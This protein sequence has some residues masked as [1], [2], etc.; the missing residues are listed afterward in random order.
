MIL[1]P[2]IDLKDGSVIR[3]IRG[4]A[5][6]MYVCEESAVILG[7][8]YARQGFRWLHVV[9]LNGATT[10]DMCNTQV[11][12]EILAHVNIPIQLG[13]GIRSLKDVEHWISRGVHRV[14]MG[15]AA[16][17]NPELIREAC[18]E[19][20]GKICVSI[21]AVQ[22]RVSLSGWTKT[23]NI[24]ALELALRYEDAG[25]SAIIY[26]D[27]TLDDTLN[28]INIDAVSDMA[29]ALTTPLIASGGLASIA[30]IEALKR[31][32]S[33]GIVGMVCGR[34]MYDGRIDP[35]EA[36][37]VAGEQEI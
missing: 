25:V 33:A 28:G 21:D 17:T 34:A 6:A 13:G 18:K 10:G 8:N 14:I 16:Q 32:E 7:N 2:S 30:D 22:G 12:E 11:V 24:K 36:L 19:F 5:D 29:F 20:P 37:R 15:T 35:Y 3:F 4:L 31:E 9:D 26:T 23:T 1:I 27:I